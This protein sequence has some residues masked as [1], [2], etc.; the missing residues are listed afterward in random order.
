MT[1]KTMEEIWAPY[2]GNQA[3]VYPWEWVGTSYHHDRLGQACR[4]KAFG[5][6]Y[7]AAWIEFEDGFTVIA[8]RTDVKGVGER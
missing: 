3:D 5:E 8:Q 1:K 7:N 2:V 6:K 4:V